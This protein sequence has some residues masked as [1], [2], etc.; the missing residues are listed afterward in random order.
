MALDNA[1]ESR[2]VADTTNPA[3]LEFAWSGRY[4]SEP[5][6]ILV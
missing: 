2:P 1:Q 3:L 6:A 5:S 4:I